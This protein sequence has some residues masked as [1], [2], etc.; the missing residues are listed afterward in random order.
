LKLDYATTMTGAVNYEV[1]ITN[2]GPGTPLISAIK[3]R[4]Y[5]L[6]ESTGTT[7]T[8][9]DSAKWTIANPAMTIN[10]PGSGCSTSTSVRPPPMT[11]YVDVGCNLASPIAA[12]D[13]LTFLVRDAATQNP[14][15][16]Y[17]YL[18]GAA[19]LTANAKMLITLNGTVV[20]GTAP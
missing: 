19:T 5:F 1:R 7:T 3:F 13:Y 9:I 8:L 15:N 18:A 20:W 6:D 4:Y 17:S 14:T 12:G 10:V 2:L 11:S 16:D